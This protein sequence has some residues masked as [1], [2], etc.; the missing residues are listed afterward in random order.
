L[1]HPREYTWDQMYLDEYA[2][3]KK[4]FHG[5]KPDEF[6]VWASKYLKEKG[7]GQAIIL[8]AGC[9]EGRNSIYLAKQGFKTY[10]IDTVSPAI[11]TGRKWVKSEGVA[12]M[13][14]LEVGDVTNLPHENNFFDA[15]IDSY[16]IEFVLE[17]EQYLKEVARVLKPKGSFFILTHI[18]PAKHGL[19]PDTLKRMLKKRF[20]IIQVQKPSNDRMTIVSEKE[21]FN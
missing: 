11:E 18:L 9:G 17:R 13:V 14:K 20:K 7:V 16:A 8:D 19:D 2:K 10:G 5:E 6:V 12:E 21:I 1:S 3:G 4:P 15:V